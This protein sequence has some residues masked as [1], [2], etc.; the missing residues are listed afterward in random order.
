MNIRGR[1][2]QS[3][4]TRGVEMDMLLGGLGGRLAQ[5]QRGPE[6]PREVERGQKKPVMRLAGDDPATSMLQ[7][8]NCNRTLEI[9]L[10]Y[11]NPTTSIM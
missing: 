1:Q 2:T 7:R 8:E 9:E 5:A 3:T 4:Y 10:T 6:R 11:M